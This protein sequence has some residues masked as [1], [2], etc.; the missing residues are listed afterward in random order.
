M[1]D[2][3]S[4]WDPAGLRPT[5]PGEDHGPDPDP[6]VRR[7]RLFFVL[8]GMLAAAMVTVGLNPI[9]ATGDLVPPQAAVLG[10]MGV[11]LGAILALALRNLRPERL[12]VAGK[13][14]LDEPVARHRRPRAE[15][16][17]AMGFAG[18]ALGWAMQAIAVAMLPVLTGLLVRL[19]HGLTW[20]LLAFAGLGVLAGARFQGLIARAVRLAVDDPELRAAYGSNG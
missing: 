12:L 3:F 5:G 17:R 6:I 15:R 14:A 18:L 8:A 7:V 19:L 16:A 1:A 10:A 4:P 2:R 9:G 11:V 13:R 20:P